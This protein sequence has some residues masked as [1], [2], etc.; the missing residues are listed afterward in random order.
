MSINYNQALQNQPK[1]ETKLQK[2]ENFLEN[3]S[4]NPS[5]Q[6][7][8]PISIV[9]A[10][11]ITLS[12]IY[13]LNKLINYLHEKRRN[14][15]LDDI[16][17]GVYYNAAD[18]ETPVRY[19]R[20]LNSNEPLEDQPPSYDEVVVQDGILSNECSPRAPTPPSPASPTSKTILLPAYVDSQ[21]FYDQ[22]DTDATTR[23]T[24]AEQVSE[25]PFDLSCP[26]DSSTLRPNNI[27]NK[28][29]SQDQDYDESV[30]QTPAPII[31]VTP[32]A[33]RIRNISNSV[34]SYSFKFTKSHRKSLNSQVRESQEREA[35]K[36]GLFRQHQVNTAIY[37]R[38]DST[39][40]HQ[41][42]QQESSRQTRSEPRAICRT[43]DEI[44]TTK[45]SDCTR[46]P[47]RSSKPNVQPLDDDK[48]GQNTNPRK[49][50]TSASRSNFT[51][52]N[53]QNQH[54]WVLPKRK[55]IV[56]TPT[57]PSRNHNRNRNEKPTTTARSQQPQ[58][59]SQ[60]SRINRNG[61]KIAATSSKNPLHRNTSNS[62]TETN[63]ENSNSNNSSSADSY[64]CRPSPIRQNCKQHYN[65]RP[66]WSNRFFGT[67]V[68]SYEED[69]VYV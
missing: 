66:S 17:H 55:P 36:M 23:A 57:R 67:A 27:R 52:V 51:T 11:F 45:R 44:S 49:M 40:D 68:P 46:T 2:F 60:I 12:I 32:T 62:T 58:T 21:N 9:L 4:Y 28:I 22:S 26:A 14:R 16:N 6:V 34:R 33:S 3:E 48:I 5:M 19:P 30:T 1:S 35:R 65:R 7:I 50:S 69:A 10:I 42:P 64:D 39:Q 20:N 31:N 15:R 25:L 47:I 61:Q 29:F 56:E 41:T 43:R 24:R 54:L 38:V 37:E 63:L 13:L 59:Q 53:S 8:I 18:V